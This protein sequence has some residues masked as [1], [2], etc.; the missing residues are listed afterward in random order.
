MHIEENRYYG[1]DPSQHQGWAEPAAAAWGT[2]FTDPDGPTIMEA[3]TEARNLIIEQ[4]LSAHGMDDEDQNDIIEAISPLWNHELPSILS[5]TT[6]TIEETVQAMADTDEITN[7]IA[8]SISAHMSPALA[9]H[10]T[11]SISQSRLETPNEQDLTTDP[12]QLE[13]DLLIDVV[14][15]VARTVTPPI[16]RTLATALTNALRSKIPRH[17]AL[18]IAQDLGNVASLDI[19]PRIVHHIATDITET[20]TEALAQATQEDTPPEKLVQ[21]IADR[22]R[23]R[24]TAIAQHS[25]NILINIPP[26]QGEENQPLPGNLLDFLDNNE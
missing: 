13:G 14:A 10:L 24:A 11:E 7:T 9:L 26:P 18:E 2:M 12:K 22:T 4:T 15:A 1:L 8:Q 19:T 3:L 23:D 21:F 6:R 17:T 20:I 16:A 25:N 5:Q